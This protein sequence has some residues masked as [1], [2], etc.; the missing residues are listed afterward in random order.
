VQRPVVDGHE[1]CAAT[2]TNRRAAAVTP[3]DYWLC[4]TRDQK[5]QLVVKCAPSDL[6]AYAARQVA[7]RKLG[8]DPQSLVVERFDQASPGVL[9]IEVRWTGSDYAPGQGVRRLQE[10]V[11]KRWRDA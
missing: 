8:V 9:V 7:A 5:Q 2:A 10:K 1:R 3:V 6:T 11:G 4:A